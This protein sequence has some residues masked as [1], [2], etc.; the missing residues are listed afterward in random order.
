VGD[1]LVKLSTNQN[2]D[3]T[4]KTRKIANLLRKALLQEGKM[5]RTLY[6][7]KLE[8]HIDYWYEGLETPKNYPPSPIAW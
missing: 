7:Y 3:K 5:E 4:M 1:N 6:E 8:E 2:K